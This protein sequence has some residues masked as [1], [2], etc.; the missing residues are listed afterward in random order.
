M[1]MT[2]AVMIFAVIVLSSTSIFKMVIDAQRK[3]TATQNI[4]EGLKYFLEVVAK[5]MRTA[6]RSNES[7]PGV[8]AGRIFATS[9][10]TYGDTISFMNY[11]NQ[12]VTYS[13]QTDANA[14]R[15]FQIE[16]DGD[17]GF[18]T[19]ARI[20]IDRLN[21]FLMTGTTTKPTVTINLLARAATGNGAS[22][23]LNI[24]TS[25]TSRVFK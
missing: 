8:V 4:E 3:G 9:S 14:V 20:S 11:Y 10:N 21:F 24:Q 5:E 6:Q 13:V 25:V 22:T 1:E 17:S 18:I 23:T 12:C 7:C 2:V 15:R 19:P 16:R